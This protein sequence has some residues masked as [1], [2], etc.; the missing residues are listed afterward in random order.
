MKVGGWSAG[1]I[2]LENGCEMKA[3]ATT[4]NAI[5]G[6]SFNVLFLDEFGVIDP[7]LADQFYTAVYPTITSGKTSRIIISS[8]PKG[9]GKLYDIWDKAVRGEGSFKHIKIDW[10]RVPGRDDEF[11]RKTIE[12]I[13]ILSWRQEYECEFLGSSKLL[14]SPSSIERYGHPAEPIRLE[15]DGKLRIYEDFKP[16]SL[17]VIGADPAVGNGGDA[18]C[19][20][21]LRFDGK[22]EI[23]EVAAF[24]DSTTNCEEYCAILMYL[25]K[26][27]GNPPIL[28]ENNG[29]GQ[30]VVNKLVYDLEY[31]NMVNLAKKGFGCPCTKQT[32]L[33]MCLLF[34]RYFEEGKLRVNDAQ[35]LRELTTFEERTTNVFKASG[36]NHDDNI[37]ALMW[38]LYY[39]ETP[40]FD[41]EDAK[42]TDLPEEEPMN[43]FISSSSSSESFF[44]EDYAGGWV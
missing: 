30:A 15:L 44:D 38:A 3:G 36:N 21:V 34:K 13:G 11:K 33:A 10:R 8:T 42:K 41:E 37:M 4:Q 26:M 29:V 20:Q 19:A 12:D 28:V 31:D 32:K 43:V 17:Y 1:R 27:F 14:V 5:R 22:D 6:F 39:M 24:S 25:A 7:K 40:Y 16:G 18:A 9:Y 35:T 23:V 2:K